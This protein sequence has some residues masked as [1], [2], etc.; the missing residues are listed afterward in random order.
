MEETINKNKELENSNRLITLNNQLER[1]SKDIDK[2]EEFNYQEQDNTTQDV[3]SPPVE[4]KLKGGMPTPKTENAQVLPG[5]LERF[6]GVVE[7]LVASFV[8]AVVKTTLTLVIGIPFSILGGAAN[9]LKNSDELNSLADAYSRDRERAKSFLPGM[10]KAREQGEQKQLSQGQIVK[11]IQELQKE[12]Q[13]ISGEIEKIAQEM[14]TASKETPRVKKASKETPRVKKASKET[15]RVK[16][17]S[18]ETP[19]VKT[20]SKETPRV[21]TASK[22][23]PRVKK[24]SK[25]TPRVKKASKNGLSITGKKD[26][27]KKTSAP[28]NQTR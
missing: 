4:K 24:A 25:E 27:G 6:L 23:T 16:K 15:P 8:S 2:L 10:N 20:A 14:K 28:L 18:K 12:K 17:A 11:K 1:L 26:E 22:E 19:W 3:H 21:K 7:Y 13:K 5:M 9:A